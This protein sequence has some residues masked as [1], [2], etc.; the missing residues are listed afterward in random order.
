MPVDDRSDKV[1]EDAVTYE[2]SDLGQSVP[3]SASGHFETASG[4]A[5]GGS[6]RCGKG[7]AEG[8]CRHISTLAACFSTVVAAVSAPAID[9]KV[10][11]GPP[12]GSF[13]LSGADETELWH[14]LSLHGPQGLPAQASPPHSLQLLGPGQDPPGPQVLQALEQQ[15]GRVA[16]LA[17][18]VKGILGLPAERSSPATLPQTQKEFRSDVPRNAAGLPASDVQSAELVCIVHVLL[19]RWLGLMERSAEAHLWGWG[20]GTWAHSL[21]QGAAALFSAC[22]QS[23]EPG[24]HI[25]SSSA[26]D[27]APPVAARVLAYCFEQSAVLLQS[28]LLACRGCPRA[29]ASALSFHAA[30]LCGQA[31]CLSSDLTGLLMLSGGVPAPGGASFYRGSDT[32][33]PHTTGGKH[34]GPLC[35]ARF[36]PDVS[37]AAAASHHLA[38]LLSVAPL[39]ALGAAISLLARESAEAIQAATG[40]CVGRSSQAASSTWTADGMLLGPGRG[41]RHTLVDDPAASTQ[42]E[43]PCGAATLPPMSTG[44]ASAAASGRCVAGCCVVPR[45]SDRRPLSRSGHASC[46]DTALGHMLPALAL[47]LALMAPAVAQR[48]TY[49]LPHQGGLEGLPAELGQLGGYSQERR[50]QG[51]RK[52]DDIATSG[53][54]EVAEDGNTEGAACAHALVS[55]ALPLVQLYSSLVRQGGGA[56]PVQCEVSGLHGLFTLT[57]STARQWRALQAHEEVSKIVSLPAELACQGLVGT[58]QGSRVSSPGFQD[59]QNT[60]WLSLPRSRILELSLL[61]LVV[62]R[63]EGSQASAA[64]PAPWQALSLHWLALE[65]QALGQTKATVPGCLTAPS[66]W[67]RPQEGVISQQ[68]GKV[69][70]VPREGPRPQLRLL[71]DVLLAALLKVLLEAATPDLL[72]RAQALLL[73]LLPLSAVSGA[74]PGPR[75][76]VRQLQAVCHAS[77]WQ[78]QVQTHLDVIPSA[79]PGPGSSPGRERAQSLQRAGLAAGHALL[80]ATIWADVLPPA[81][82][83]EGDALDSLILRQGSLGAGQDLVGGMPWGACKQGSGGLLAVES[84]RG[85]LGSSLL[86]CFQRLGPRRSGEDEPAG[87]LEGSAQMGESGLHRARGGAMGEAAGAAIGQPP[88]QWDTGPGLKGGLAQSLRP[89]SAEQRTVQ[90]SRPAG[91]KVAGEQRNVHKSGVGATAEESLLADKPGTAGEG[92]A[93][94]IAGNAEADTE[95]ER[96]MGWVLVQPQQLASFLSFLTTGL[97]EPHGPA[98]SHTQADPL[99]GTSADLGRG[100]VCGMRGLAL[101]ASRGGDAGGP[102]Q[103]RGLRHVEAS[104]G[105]ATATD[106]DN[107]CSWLQRLYLSCPARHTLRCTAM[108][109]AADEEALAWPHAQPSPAEGEAPREKR[110]EALPGPKPGRALWESCNALLSHSPLAAGFWMAHVAARQMVCS[111]IQGPERGVAAALRTVWGSLGAVVRE[112]ERTGSYGRTRALEDAVAGGRHPAESPTAGPPQAGAGTQLKVRLCW[113]FP[114]ALPPALCLRAFL[115]TGLVDSLELH[116]AQAYFAAGSLLLAPLPE[117]E[118]ASYAAQ[119][120]AATSWLASA[121]ARVLQCSWAGGDK[122]AVVRHGVALLEG[123]QR[124]VLAAQ[125]NTMGRPQGGLA[126]AKKVEGGLG[127]PAEGAGARAAGLPA[128][129]G[130]REGEGLLCVLRTV[131]EAL[132]ELQEPDAIAGLQSWLEEGGAQGL[133][134]WLGEGVD[135]G[136]A[137]G[138]AGQKQEP[139]EGLAPGNEDPEPERRSGSEHAAGRGVASRWCLTE[140]RALQFLACGRAEEGVEALLPSFLQ[141]AA[142]APEGSAGS[143][144][145]GSEAAPGGVE[146]ESQGGPQEEHS[147]P[148]HSLGFSLWTLARACCAAADPAS[149]KKALEVSPFQ[150]AASVEGLQEAVTS[151]WVAQPEQR[152][153]PLL[154]S[155]VQGYSLFFLHHCLAHTSIMGPYLN[156]GPIPQSWACRSPL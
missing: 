149:F 16:P 81:V 141:A 13:L 1:C 34:L 98:A 115:V 131:A 64:G 126:S 21:W 123:S 49:L 17:D 117:A 73:S 112:I 24:A 140:L 41:G 83:P 129:D 7:W 144:G 116:L 90:G 4:A 139:E 155:S 14:W 67:T 122:A 57:T 88:E 28:C 50:G 51:G 86:P 108:G 137:K 153:L 71:P 124:S 29:S 148:S 42:A 20:E 102:W 76:S 70:G 52:E 138:A 26:Q 31:Q 99:Q 11:Q 69:V 22:P 85:L 92:E 25:K 133:Q 30:I 109:G 53:S 130:A 118:G 45:L 9:G 97:P 48:M 91:G 103:G 2:S 44:G 59:G 127:V 36:H 104:K 58:A 136:P 135:Q 46:G 37:V 18:R 154:P 72:H 142:R 61:P 47:N 111:G 84:W 134:S 5:Q 96:E 80:I 106:W 38:C 151:T 12:S 75:L 113:P 27:Q 74:A 145:A 55:L 66:S 35:P 10:G 40:T 68:L 147:C 54:R 78:L 23:S 15:L 77:L 128:A 8:R 152:V 100:G 89:S 56:L 43:G 62:E 120:A 19:L 6:E 95:G 63:M 79:P 39:P 125:G 132:S 146:A 156:H 105:T 93:R 110:E 121:R 94:P 101:L 114:L 107:H 119:Q 87:K 33:T 150:C 82:R 60:A 143:E 65:L 3:D 32:A